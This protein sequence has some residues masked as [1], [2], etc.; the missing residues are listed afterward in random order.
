M[1]LAGDPLYQG[2]YCLDPTCWRVDTLAR[3][4]HSTWD[5]PHP[6]APQI[7]AHHNQT[8]GS[9]LVKLKTADDVRFAAL[10]P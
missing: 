5:N 7:T 4:A 1:F 6:K 9:G 8:L 3:E 10:Q 2:G